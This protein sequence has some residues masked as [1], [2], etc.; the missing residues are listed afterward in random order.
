MNQRINQ[1][2]HLLL[3]KKVKK[4]DRIAVLLY[5][6]HPYL[7]IFY[8]LSKIGAIFVPLNWRLA[9]PELEFIMKDSGSRMLIF[10]PEFEAVVTSIRSHLILSNGDYLNIGQP[11]PDWAIDFEKALLENPVHEPSF[12]NSWG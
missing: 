2:S 9:G 7:E 1:L 12:Y 4:G 5:N 8:A 3:G 10:E 11:C 6:S